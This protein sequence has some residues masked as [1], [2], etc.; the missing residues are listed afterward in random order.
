[1]GH[2]PRQPQFDCVL[3]VFP[4]RKDLHQG[5]QKWFECFCQLVGDHAKTW[6]IQLIVDKRIYRKLEEPHFIRSDILVEVVDE[7]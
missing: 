6:Q 2:F 4:D 1:M 3:A 5:V 7:E